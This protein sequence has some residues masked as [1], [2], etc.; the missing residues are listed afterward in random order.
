M[1]VFVLSR[2]D[3]CNS[4]LSGCPKQFIEKIQKVQNSTARLVLN[5]NKRDHV[6]PL[7][8]TLHW[9]PIQAR[10]K[11]KLSALCHSFFSDTAHVYLSDF[12][13]YSPSRQLRS[14]SDS[15][16][17]RIPQM[18]TKTVGHRSFP[19]ATPSDWNS[20]HRKIRDIRSTTA[21]ITAL[22]THL[23]KFSLCWLNLYPPSF[24]ANYFSSPPVVFVFF[25]F[26]LLLLLLL[27]F[28]FVC[29]C[30]RVCLM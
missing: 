28:F 11:Y 20:L 12:H 23:F 13:V 9:L 5:A 17:L 15:R 29:V 10:I 6:S 22:K 30:V 21:F 26:C 18:K 16:T 24:S 1:S 3:Y 25:V 14:S 2:L 4:L 19:C 8:R 27:F 7:L